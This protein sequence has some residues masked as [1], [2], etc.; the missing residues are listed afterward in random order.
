[1]RVWDAPCGRA[2]RARGRAQRGADGRPVRRS[3]CPAQMQRSEARRR[4]AAVRCA[5]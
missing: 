5:G 2:G 1:M 3:R 4:C